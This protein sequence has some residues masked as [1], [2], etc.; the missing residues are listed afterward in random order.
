MKPPAKED[1]VRILEAL[2]DDT[3]QYHRLALMY[4]G[5]ATKG[6]TSISDEFDETPD[7]NCLECG[8][9]NE[10]DYLIAELLA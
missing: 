8:H 7:A 4:E 3:R 2:I 9:I 6:H 10:A 5:E 1:I